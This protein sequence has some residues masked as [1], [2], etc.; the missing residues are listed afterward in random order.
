MI[1]VVDNADSF[2]FN[3]V[4]MLRSMGE[5]VA[6]RRSHSLSWREMEAME[7]SCVIISPGPG[8][9][10]DAGLSM[11]MIR[12]FG[13]FLPILG[14]CLGHQAVAAVF[15]ARVVRAERI[16]HGKTSRIHHDGA[17]I[18]QGMPEPFEA[19]R[20]HSLVVAPG[21]VPDCLETSAWTGSGEIMGL[22]HREVPAEGIQFHPES[23]LTPLGEGIVRNFVQRAAK[24][25]GRSPGN[26]TERVS[27]SACV[28]DLETAHRIEPGLGV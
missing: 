21:S 24:L 28:P 5:E 4:Q 25:Q 15:G 11:E 6:V 10:E 23:V 2:T 22:R 20:Y 14:V 19:G 26:E 8:G 17:T 16:L 18:F 7:P 27:C 3:L 9:P 1:L 12:R 13:R